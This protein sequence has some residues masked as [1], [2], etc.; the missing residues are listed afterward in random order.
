[1]NCPKCGSPLEQ[2][3]VLDQTFV[4]S[5][6]HCSG[7]FY[8]EGE[9]AV[10]LELRG[11]KT[12]K[13]NCP[14]C[15]SAMQTGT[16]YDGHLELDRCGSC[17]GIWFDAG[18]LESL[19]HLSGVEQIVKP[20]GAAF[21]FEQPETPP[22]AKEHPAPPPKTDAAGPPRK[23][24]AAPAATDDDPPHRAG[25]VRSDENNPDARRAPR[26][27]LGGRTFEHFQTSVPVTTYVLGE[28]PW[29]AKV[30]DTVQMRDFISPPRL[31]SEE[32]SKDE[33]VW[34]LGEYAEP[35]EVWAAFQLPGTPP[36]K[37]GVSAAQPNAWSENLAPMWVAFGIAAAV[38]VGSFLW[39]SQTALERVVFESHLVFSSSDTEKSRVTDVFEVPGD[40]SNVEI[41][42][43]TS[44]DN[45]W[46]YFDVALIDSD[47]D[48][49]FDFG[50]E[51]S[52][53]HGVEDGESWSEGTNW[54]TLYVP[55]VPA[56][57][58]Y[59]RLEPE[60]D[61][62]PLPLQVRVRRDVPLARLPLI[63]L[64]LLLIPPLFVWARWRVFEQARWMDSDHPRAT[65][66][67]DE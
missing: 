50:Q 18:E 27:K 56:G 23:K 58:Y 17:G 51:L 1:M 28:F 32:V 43:E 30:G 40:V 11:V 65:G 44:L 31:L 25:V 54:E 46:A 14:S 64:L 22:A 60:T 19:R 57:H 62:T 16:V 12:A 9:L 15:A 20:V 24:K 59:L 8:A 5:C 10:R 34:T 6:P 52:Y 26:V 63:A 2:N 29:V 49:A 42:L 36:P 3:E 53:Y 45:H 21:A 61:V 7:A 35:E 48:R 38:C 55:Q 47:T 41:H 67:D 37:R 33:T 13:W 4:H 39:Q 66:G